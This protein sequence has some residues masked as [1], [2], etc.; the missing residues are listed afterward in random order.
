M[1]VRSPTH[2]SGWIR[3]RRRRRRRPLLPHWSNLRWRQSRWKLSTVE[4]AH[5]IDIFASG[6]ACLWRCSLARR[7]WERRA[8]PSRDSLRH[9]GSYGRFY[10]LAFL[11]KV[12]GP[13]PRMPAAPWSAGALIITTVPPCTETLAIACIGQEVSTE[14]EL[15]HGCSVLRTKVVYM[16]RAQGPIT[17]VGKGRKRSSVLCES[18]VA[19]GSEAASASCRPFATT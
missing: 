2:Q 3:W 16:D 11:P 19:F 4:R 7:I 18:L 10:I 6:E 14:L 9:N 15:G 17:G 5:S 1:H 12:R 13:G 8:V